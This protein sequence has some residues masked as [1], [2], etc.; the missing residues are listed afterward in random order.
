MAK[1]FYSKNSK[2]EFT[3]DW[4]KLQLQPVTV[5]FGSVKNVDQIPCQTSFDKNN[6]ISVIKTKIIVSA[7]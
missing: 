7:A 5:V 6:K 2:F 3:L 1:V 4:Y